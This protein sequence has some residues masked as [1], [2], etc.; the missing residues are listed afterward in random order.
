MEAS[1]VQTPRYIELAVISC[2]CTLSLRFF[3]C[4]AERGVCEEV[5]RAIDGRIKGLLIAY[6]KSRANAVY[7]SIQTLVTRLWDAVGGNNTSD[8]PAN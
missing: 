4:E 8:N 3:L 7:A 1:S 5:E 2:P 6:A